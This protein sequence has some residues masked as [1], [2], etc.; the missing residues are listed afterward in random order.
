MLLDAVIYCG[1][2]LYFINDDDGISGINE[3]RLKKP[4]CVMDRVLWMFCVGNFG[5]R[6]SEAF[7]ELLSALL[8]EIE[9]NFM[10]K[11]SICKFIDD[12]CFSCMPGTAYF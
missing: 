12:I 2:L 8:K 11:V 7:Q 1:R 4:E 5:D 6:L 10:L 3:I 9:I